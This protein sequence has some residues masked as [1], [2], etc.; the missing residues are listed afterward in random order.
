MKMVIHQMD[1]KKDFRVEMKKFPTNLYRG[2]K[3]KTEI[4]NFMEK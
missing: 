4:K 1:L 2:D 3:M